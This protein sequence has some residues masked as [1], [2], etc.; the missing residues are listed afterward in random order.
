MLHYPRA[1]FNGHF[2]AD[3]QLPV[4]LFDAEVW[5]VWKFSVARHCPL[6]LPTRGSRTGPHLFFN[7]WWPLKERTLMPLLMLSTVIVQ[8]TMPFNILHTFEGLDIT[9]CQIELSVSNDAVWA[10]C[11]SKWI[12]CWKGIWHTKICTHHVCGSRGNQIMQVYVEMTCCLGMC[13][14]YFLSGLWQCWFVIRRS[15]S[16]L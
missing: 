6:D 10:A 8:T 5:T 14:N 9:T 3:P 11:V 7:S 2:S 12:V 13:M 16:S 1:P 15:P 4:C